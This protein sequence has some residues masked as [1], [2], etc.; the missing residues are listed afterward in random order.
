[1]NDTFK[2]VGKSYKNCDPS[3]AQQ[4]ALKAS[5]TM[6]ST[7][8]S[9]YKTVFG[10]GSKL[11][12]SLKSGYDKIINTTHGMTSEELAARRS[13]VSNRAAASEKS[14]Q[15]SI[16]QRAAMTGAVP[17][18]E[19][20]IVQSERAQAATE[21]QS[22]AA[23]QQADITGEDYATGRKERDIAMGAEAKLPGE[24]FSPST[25]IAGADIAAQKN[26]EEQANANEQAS[27]SW[28]GMVGG[29]ASAGIGLAGD[30]C[31]D[32]GTLI[33]MGDNTEK[34]AD[35]IKIGDKVWGFDGPEAVKS[36]IVSTQPRV[37]VILDNDY[38]VVVSSSHTFLSPIGGYIEAAA[39]L[40]RYLRTDDAWNKVVKIE[41]MGPGEVVMIK[42]TGLH[43]YIS[44]GIWSLE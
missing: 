43:G 13:E 20:G 18:V 6:E 8:A 41:V 32:L 39:S 2:Y 34:R 4:A 30:L 22:K 26:E 15:R 33:L 38:E 5:Q 21:I 11:Y 42:L 24:V 9:S 19:S 44:N 1:M 37:K 14:V 35:E 17:G 36:L 16:G 25:E 28:M 31:V 40:N 12:S 23:Q 7:L 27:S 29:L 10:I 3:G